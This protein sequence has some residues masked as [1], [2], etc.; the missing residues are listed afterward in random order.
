MRLVRNPFGYQPWR[1]KRT[2]EAMFEILESDIVVMQE[3]KI[4]RKDLRDEM[5]L[6]PGWDVYFSLPRYKK[7][8]SGVAVYTRNASC[9]PI[10]VE[11]GI[12]GILT[13]P[14][15]SLCYADLPA[16]QQIGGYPRPSQLAGP[17]D[18]AALDSVG[19]CIVMEFP[20]F[21][22]IGLYCP[23]NRDESRDD[24]RLGYL[25]ALDARV[26]NLTAQ[27]KRVVVTG[28]LNIIRD[29]LDT[30]NAEEQLRK[31]GMT[32]EEYVSTPARRI[33]N[34]M[35]V[36]GNVIGDSDDGRSKPVLVDLCRA[37]HPHRKGMFTCWETKVNARPGNF[38]SRIDYVLCSP[39]CEGWFCE[40]NIQEGLM[41]SDHCPVY[42][43]LKDVVDHNDETVHVRD[44]MNPPGMFKGGKRLRDWS[45]K[46]LLPLS[47]KLIPEFDRRRTIRD[48]FSR[49]PA[50]S[51]Q[52][53]RN[54]HGIAMLG[55][56]GAKSNDIHNTANAS[57]PQRRLEHT[58][59][60]SS[61]AAIEESVSSRKRLNSPTIPSKR[62]NDTASDIDDCK[63]KKS[64]VRSPSA[65]KRHASNG[66][67]TLK[68]FF[69][70]KV[71]TAL[72]DRASGLDETQSASSANAV[73]PPESM[74]QG[75]RRSS[76]NGFNDD[77]SKSEDAIEDSKTDSPGQKHV[78]DQIAAK[79]S[80]EKLLGRRIAPRCEHGE[81]CVSFL[82]KKAGINCGRSFYMCPRP[83][84]PSGA[85][86]RNSQ[87][88]CGTFI[89]SSD[90]SGDA[91]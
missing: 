19:R 1:D 83:L 78:L 72:V 26:R 33:L 64:L 15:S 63:R 79:E 89:W 73:E 6:I 27:G 37:F 12:M 57:S 7:G 49:T 39:E 52:S 46:D 62:N 67:S 60:A 13:P 36:G 45:Q 75:P 80:W 59:E 10:R 77:S 53:L 41:G 87:W 38:G 54:N 14:N 44:I 30:A 51:G 4:Q 69:K 66:Q 91:G 11:E 48:M 25:N 24:F 40:S 20:A 85:K 76:L 58:T 82:T 88:R 42:A 18:A 23:A 84:G 90:W 61:P 34:Q 70:P 22:L 81:A 74:K 35:L 32:A 2:F 5:V 17:L 65:T 8:Y 55:T 43:V 16:N 68:G 31:H 86:E 29:Q 50:I 21:V 47:G 9:A 71:A 28:D 56:A 3:C